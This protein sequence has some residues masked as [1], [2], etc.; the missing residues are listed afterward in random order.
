[1]K[2]LRNL[3]RVSANKWTD[4]KQTFN[5]VE[6]DDSGYLYAQNAIIGRLL[7]VNAN[8]RIIS[9][10]SLSDKIAGTSGR[11]TS[12]NDGDGGTVIDLVDSA[13][14][15]RYYTQ[16]QV[17]ALITAGLQSIV[18]HDGNVVTHE[19]EVVTYA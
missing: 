11:I 16:A 12:T 2:K 14:D 1:M 17:S 6:G 13:F 15:G 19:G 3:R 7:T 18:C 9:V 4:G 8:H 10:I 5:F